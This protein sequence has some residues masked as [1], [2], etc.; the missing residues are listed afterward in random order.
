MTDLTMT[1]TGPE[2]VVFDR[3]GVAWANSRDVAACFGKRHDHVLRNI[4]NL[5]KSLDSPK[6]G[7][8]FFVETAAP[9][10]QGIAR[11]TVDMTRDGFTLL[12]MGFTGTRALGFKL[13]YIEQF[14]RMEADLRRPP[15]GALAAEEVRRI[16]VAVADLKR[17]VGELRA[18]QDPRVAVRDYI[19]VRELLDEAKA[20][21]KGRNGLNR[22]IGNT[23]RSL[24]LNEGVSLR[25]CPRTGTWLFPIAVAQLWMRR[26]GEALV[27]EHNAAAIG[28]G[29]LKFPDRRRY[30]GSDALGPEA[31]S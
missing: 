1:V 18:A 12:A 3:D 10:G 25:R 2:P 14:N 4:D 29:V 31:G 13:R 7:S 26:H 11:R 5:L 30:P 23:L 9:D 20:R 27:R 21:P 28:Q 16:A 6:L 15:A 8:G 22:R 17:E 24:A 19:S